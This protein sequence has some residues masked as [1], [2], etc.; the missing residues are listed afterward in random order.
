MIREHCP[1]VLVWD[2]P[3]G[4]PA[5]AIMSAGSC[6]VLRLDETGVQHPLKTLQRYRSLGLLRGRRIGR[7]VRFTIDDCRNLVEQ[8]RALVNSQQ[9]ARG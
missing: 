7:C 8:P 9:R 6:D 3:C 1:G 5:R 4:K 2:M